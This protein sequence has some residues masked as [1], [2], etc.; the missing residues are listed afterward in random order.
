MTCEKCWDDAYTLSRVTG[1]P[2]AEHYRELLKARSVVG[3]M[4]SM[5]EQA[6]QFWDEARQRDS[7]E[8]A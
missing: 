2:Q 3:P 6:G 7:R 4:C 1:R 8:T 5:R